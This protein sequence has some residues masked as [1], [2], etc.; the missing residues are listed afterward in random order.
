MCLSWSLFNHF[1]N[2]ILE[3]WSHL[4]IRTVNHADVAHLNN[5]EKRVF[6]NQQEISFHLFEVVP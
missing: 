1:I 5:V 3:I 6:E 2:N 4:K